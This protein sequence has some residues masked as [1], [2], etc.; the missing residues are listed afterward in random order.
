M[1]GEM[2]DKMSLKIDAL[3]QEVKD[4]E[5]RH[6][7]VT[8]ELR[9]TIQEQNSKISQLQ[10]QMQNC[11]DRTQTNSYSRAV[12]SGPGN[13]SHSED[14]GQKFQSQLEQISASSPK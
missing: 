6:I 4:Q 7:N 2:I 3:I 9:K 1:M 14:L 12:R 13:K 5:T 10:D 8:K 11:V